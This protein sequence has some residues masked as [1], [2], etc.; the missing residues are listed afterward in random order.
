MYVTY[1]SAEHVLRHGWILPLLLLLLVVVVV[2]VQHQVT[3]FH[4]GEGM[5]PRG[6][7]VILGPYQMHDVCADSGQCYM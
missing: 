7:D 2:V 5:L 1:S 3:A 4:V 6:L